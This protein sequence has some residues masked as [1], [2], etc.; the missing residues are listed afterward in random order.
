[1][2]IGMGRLVHTLFPKS[3]FFFFL[4]VKLRK[5]T[6]GTMMRRETEL[7]C[8]CKWQ[9][10]IDEGQSEIMKGEHLENEE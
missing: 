1:L 2:E 6:K 4:A 7:E 3:T 8:M 9:T 10:D 5:Q